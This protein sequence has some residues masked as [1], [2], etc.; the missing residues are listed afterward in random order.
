[1]DVNLHL[2]SI[3]TN[4]NKHNN[5]EVLLIFIFPYNCAGIYLCAY[6]Y[7]SVFFNLCIF[8]LVRTHVYISIHVSPYVD[9][10]VLRYMYTFTFE[11]VCL[12]VY[13]CGHQPASVLLLYWWSLNVL[14]PYIISTDMLINVAF[15]DVCDILF[16]VSILVSGL[17]SCPT[18]WQSKH[19]VL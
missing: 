7:T 6:L 18:P 4:Y 14:S 15:V 10:Y 1:M 17:L 8:V 13:M 2:M 16:A 19:A 3:T 12:C 9:A 5:N 11:R